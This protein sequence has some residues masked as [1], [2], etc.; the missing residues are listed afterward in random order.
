[1]EKESVLKYLKSSLRYDG[2]DLLQFRNMTVETGI[3]ESAEGSARVVLGDTIVLA[4]VKMEIGAPYPD[5]PKQGGLMVNAELTPLSSP[6][7]ETG[8]PGDEANELARII[9]RGIRESK[10]IDQEALCIKEGEKVWTVLIDLV[11]VNASGNLIDACAIATIAALKDAR[12]PAAN[13]KFV[14][15]YTK[16]TD[17][18]L[19]LQEDREPITVT[20]A[21]IGEHLL[22][23]TTPEEEDVIDARLSVAIIPNGK[24]SAMQKGGDVPFSIEEIDTIIG[25]AIEKSAE[26]RKLLN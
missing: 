16:K 4:G 6:K 18:R 17:K 11:T 8:P 22:A 24:V 15:D 14:I 1:M 10:F 23:D 20:V 2:R 26:L 5:T 9:D 19:P 13:E 7:F 21:K 12:F 3:S 25:I